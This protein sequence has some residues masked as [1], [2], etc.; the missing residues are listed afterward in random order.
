MMLDQLKET[1]KT[2]LPELDFVMGWTTGYDPLHAT[3]LY[4]YEPDDVDQLIWGPLN[5]HNLAVHL[6]ALRHK[7]VGIVVKG[8]DSR[9]VV[10]L[11]QE[12]LIDRENVVIFGAPCNGVVDMTKIRK[13][14]P[15]AH[16]ARSVETAD[17]SLTITTDKDTHTLSL[18][19]VMADKCTRCRFP[20]AVE[21]DHFVGEKR[22]PAVETD[23]YADLESFESQGFAE[24][25]DFWM[26]EMDRCIRCYACRNACPLCVCRD[27]CVAQSREPHWVS[28][29]D[30]VRDKFMFQVIHAIHMAGRCTECGECERACPMDIPVLLLKRKL[31]N[32]IHDLFDYDAGL[33]AEARPPLL[34]FK[35]EE[36]SIKEKD[37]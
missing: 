35:L 7:K 22:I 17:N 30:G 10:E 8:C 32:V 20:N 25:R 13:A 18:A 15:D 11:L 28:Q 26:A 12:N 9:S 2:A 1:I 37:W 4:M 24:R 6:P 27:H 31:G 16:F 19:E 5:V 36:D 23:P 3:P 21:A 29:R 34:A 14:V 33:D